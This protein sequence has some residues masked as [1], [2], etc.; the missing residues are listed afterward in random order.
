[1]NSKFRKF[2]TVQNFKKQK[3]KKTTKFG[4][5]KFHR[6]NDYKKPI[7]KNERKKKKEEVLGGCFLFH[8]LL[9]VGFL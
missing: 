2:K 4:Q 6:I 9:F 1:M 8:F 7:K 3:K 5:K